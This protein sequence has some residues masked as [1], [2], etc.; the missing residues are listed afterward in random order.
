M[1][2]WPAW[3]NVESKQGNEI[4]HVDKLMEFLELK[5]MRRASTC[6]DGPERGVI[7]R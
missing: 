4:V 6:G 1:Q 3:C 7:S 2:G 5:H